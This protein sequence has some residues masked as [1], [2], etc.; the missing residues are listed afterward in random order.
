MYA[1][2]V[3]LI[4]VV[5]DLTQRFPGCRGSEIGL[6]A[7][8][9]LRRMLAFNPRKRIGVDEAL[10]HPFL[11]RNFKPEDFAAAVHTEQ[12][13]ENLEVILEDSAH[14]LD[15]VLQEAELYLKR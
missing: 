1:S 6:H 8:D 5:Q 9:L 15:S 3:S 14:L 7:L 13:E 10:Q 4:S 11:R 12:F 2:Y